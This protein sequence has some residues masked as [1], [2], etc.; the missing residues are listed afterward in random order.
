MLGLGVGPTAKQPFLGPLTNRHTYPLEDT[1]MTCRHLIPC[2]IDCHPPTDD[3]GQAARSGHPKPSSQPCVGIAVHTDTRAT[4]DR[5]PVPGTTTTTR[6][7]PTPAPVRGLSLLRGGQAVSL[8]RNHCPYVGGRRLAV[9][10]CAHGL[11]PRILHGFCPLGEQR[12]QL[13]GLGLVGGLGPR[14]R[15]WH[16]LVSKS[17]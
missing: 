2:P 16:Q 10:R 5:A 1:R 11:L 14:W 13:A 17:R 4:C 8:A 6:Y 12:G 3:P 9:C 15:A 7:A